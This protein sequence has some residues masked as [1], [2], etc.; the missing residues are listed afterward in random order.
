MHIPDQNLSWQL[1]AAYIPDQPWDVV[2]VGA[3]PAGAAAAVDLAANRHRVLLLDKQ[4]FP[5]EK[6]CGDGLL[7]DTMRIH[8][9]MGIGDRVRAAGHE[10]NTAALF[11]PSKNRVEIPGQYL[12]LKRMLL[13]TIVAR[14]AVDSGAVFACG[15]VNSLVSEP[16]G[17]V[18]LKIRD[19][20]KFITARICLVA[21]GSDLRLLRKSGWAAKRKPNAIAA[22]CYVRSSLLVDRLIFSYDKSVIPGYGWIFPMGDQEYNIGCGIP[23]GHA[24]KRNINL[25]R[26]FKN[27]VDAFPMARKLI[28]KSQ[29][30]TRLC[31]AALRLDFEGA[32]PFVKGPIVAVGETIGT[33]LPFSG[34]GIGKAMESGQLAA[35]AT[36]K[37]LEMGELNQLGHYVEEVRS[38]LKVRYQGYRIAEKWL[39]KPWLNDI[40]LER[41]A[42]SNYAQKI[43]AG[44]IAETQD[45]LDIFSLTGIIK[46]LWK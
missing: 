23:L 16:D 43:L 44:I 40:L 24:L 29:S 1:E 9:D 14:K 11:S 35:K 15:E 5:R 31:G 26:I 38:N 2:I 13:D 17:S 18:S 34:E 6:V 37:A 33:T 12:T 46:T 39:A 42:R 21:T 19:S 20:M 45:P 32:Y 36:I 25:K 8:D 4:R 41:F 28:Q 7:P 30:T 22:R 10:M 27:F 3:G